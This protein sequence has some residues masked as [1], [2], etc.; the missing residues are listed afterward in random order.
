MNDRKSAISSEWDGLWTLIW[1]TNGARRPALTSAMNSKLKSLHGCH[2]LQGA[3]AYCGARTTDH[4]ACYNY[5]WEW[6]STEMADVAETKNQNKVYCSLY[7][8]THL[9]SWSNVLQRK[10]HRTGHRLTAESDSRKEVS[11]RTPHLHWTRP[12]IVNPSLASFAGVVKQAYISYSRTVL[13]K[14]AYIL[15]QNVGRHCSPTYIML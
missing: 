10:P 12:H 6:D 13:S 1:Y 14:D 5:S 4:T 3:G 2:H 9:R 11:A 7:N 8:K 15:C